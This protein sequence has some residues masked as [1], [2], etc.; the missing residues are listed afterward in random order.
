MPGLRREIHT[1]NSNCCSH[2]CHFPAWQLACSQVWCS[3]AQTLAAREW[4]KADAGEPPPLGTNSQH[5]THTWP[6]PPHAAPADS[7]GLPETAAVSLQCWWLPSDE[8]RPKEILQENPFSQ[9]GSR[10]AASPAA[11]PTTA[12]TLQG[13]N[14]RITLSFI[15]HGL[16]WKHKNYLSMKSE[17]L[18]AEWEERRAVT[19]TRFSQAEVWAGPGLTKDFQLSR[20]TEYKHKKGG[21]SVTS[22]THST[23]NIQSCLWNRSLDCLT[24]K[25]QDSCWKIIILCIFKNTTSLLLC[26]LLFLYAGG[27]KPHPFSGGL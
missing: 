4:L 8:M 7:P 25:E 12:C 17:L 22:H 2:F 26:V 24:D 1:T 16:D 6:C 21:L 15:S 14:T 13:P 3:G 19:V 20:H 23:V 11:S 27:H 9:L 5:N 10:A 18:G